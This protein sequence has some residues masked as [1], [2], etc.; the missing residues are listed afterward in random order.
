MCGVILR[1]GQMKISYCLFSQ[2]LLGDDHGWK[3]LHVDDNKP[4]GWA[5]KWCMKVVVSAGYYMLIMAAIVT[6]AVAAASI[7]FKHDGRDRKVFYQHYYYLEVSI[8][9]RMTRKASLTDV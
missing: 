1:I 9:H 7:S 6:N 5:P 8:F 2:V 4:R 3:L